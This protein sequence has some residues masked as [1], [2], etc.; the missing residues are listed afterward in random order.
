MALSVFTDKSKKPEAKELQKALGNN[1]KLWEEIKNYVFVNYPQAAEEWNFSG[2]NYGWGYRLRDK[3][4]VIVYLTPCEGYFKF[5]LVFGEKATAA[6]FKSDIQQEIKDIIMASK[7]YAEG[8]GV[9]IDV[10]S[11]GIINDI[12]KLILIKLTN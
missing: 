12:K 1:Y 3:K 10:K 11:K 2:K 7:V 4:R 5:S 8:R 9:R 6:S